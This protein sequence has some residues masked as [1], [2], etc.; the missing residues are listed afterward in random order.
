[1][2]LFGIDPV[3]PILN[4]QPVKDFINKYTG[5]YAVV[6][7]L[8]YKS[9]ALEATAHILGMSESVTVRIDEFELANDCSYVAI[10]KM[11]ASAEGVANLCDDFLVGRKFP[12][13]EDKRSLLT[14]IK[15]F[16]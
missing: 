6:E 16:L 10:K 4:S 11:S 9:G 3:N 14:P 7:S 15:V 5:K 2:A 1:M 12:I 8:R 13:P